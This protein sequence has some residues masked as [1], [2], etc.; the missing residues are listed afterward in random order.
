MLTTAG[1]TAFSLELTRLRLGRTAL[2][3]TLFHEQ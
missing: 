3:L 2:F 1:G